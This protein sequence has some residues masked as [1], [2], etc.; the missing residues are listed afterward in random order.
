MIKIGDTL[1]AIFIQPLPGKNVVPALNIKHEYVCK[2]IFYDKDDNPHID[3]GLRMTH[4]WVTSYATGEILPNHT[5]WC[6]PNR[7]IIIKSIPDD[8]VI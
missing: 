6:H 7:F 4:D 3:V 2:D 1:K 8:P 5:H